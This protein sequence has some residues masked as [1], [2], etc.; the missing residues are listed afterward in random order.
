MAK[1]TVWRK[2]SRGCNCS[3]HKGGCHQTRVSELTHT[4]GRK[5]EKK[6][7]RQTCVKSHQMLSGTRKTKDETWAQG[8]GSVVTAVLYTQ[9]PFVSPIS[10]PC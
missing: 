7:W 9:N 1:A 3:T 5:E 4:T 6:H 8:R 2:G 10:S